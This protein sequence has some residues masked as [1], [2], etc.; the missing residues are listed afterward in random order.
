[1]GG[2][3][4]ICPVQDPIKYA[5]ESALAAL[6]ENPRERTSVVPR[7]D[8]MPTHVRARGN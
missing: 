8:R 4:S 7:G 3:S 6:V 2:L 1:L 5:T